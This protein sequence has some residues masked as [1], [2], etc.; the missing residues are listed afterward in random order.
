MSNKSILVMISGSGSNLQAFIDSQAAGELPGKIIAVLSNK[1]Q[2]YG[3]ERAKQANIDTITLE[4]TNFDSREAF[5]QAM[6]EKI[7]QYQPDLII[8]AGFMRILSSAFVK[9][10][11]GK[12]LNIHPSLLP[13]YP[14]L[15]THK[16][17]IENQDEYH[18][19]SVHFV[20]EELDGGPVIAQAKLTIATMNEETLTK[21]IQKMEHKLYPQVAKWFLQDKLIMQQDGVYFENKRLEKP[22]IFEYD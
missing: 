13:K 14:G 15:N 2:A 4:H 18:G 16:R 8:L 6:I 21:N 20:T 5:D 10:Y 1:A 3:L 17:A 7:D 12:L 19:T 22:I 11:S 9:Q